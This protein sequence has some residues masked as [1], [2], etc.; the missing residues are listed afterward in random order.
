[1][2]LGDK[3]NYSGVGISLPYINNPEFVLTPEKNL[4]ACLN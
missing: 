2:V 4:L 3:T 1:M